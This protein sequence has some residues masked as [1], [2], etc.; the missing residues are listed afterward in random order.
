[1]FLICWFLSFHFAIILR[2]SFPLFSSC[3]RQRQKLS[4]RP[5]DDCSLALL[6][7]TQVNKFK[8]YRMFLPSFIKILVFLMLSL[9]GS[10][11]N[12]CASLDWPMQL[13]VNQLKLVDWKVTSTSHWESWNCLRFHEWLCRL[14]TYEIKKHQIFKLCH[15]LINVSLTDYLCLWRIPA[16]HSTRRCRRRFDPRSRSFSL[17]SST[18]IFS[19]LSSM[20][21]MGYRRAKSTQG[22]TNFKKRS[23]LANNFGITTR[24][25]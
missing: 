25:P 4:R 1:M 6:E 23:F 13:P 9:C 15:D 3:T 21:S 22:N 5:L 11:E 10:R 20:F 24:G 16:T 12:I 14:N 2:S 8:W 17:S 18:S 7:N 19:S